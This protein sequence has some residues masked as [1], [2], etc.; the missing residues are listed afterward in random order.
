ME[1][2]DKITAVGKMQKYIDAN[3]E[4]EI[5]LEA[6]SRAAGYSKYHAA[7]IFKELTGKT[8]FE[9]VRALRLTRAA[10]ALRDTEGK[11]IDAALDHGF[12]SHDGF[13]RAFT[14]QFGVRPGDYSR[15]KP[16]V[17][18]FVHY[19]IEANYPPK[20]GET[21]M[22]QIRP[23]MTVTAME[24]PAR[25]LILV[26]SVKATDYFSFCEEI[27][28]E[29]EGLFNSI[30]EKFDNAALLTLPQNL[31]TPGTG[32]TASGVEVPIGYNKPLP[33]GCDIIELPPCTML[34]FQGAPYQEENSF[35]EAIMLLWEIMDEYDPALYGLKYAPELAPYF[36]FGA[37]AKTGARMARPVGKI[38]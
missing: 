23:T 25:K 7:R 37:E 30:K 1:L 5:T 12:E 2:S 33:G 14:R 32:N 29:W 4:G 38:I 34:Y 24:R 20:E 13:T 10:Q 8:P 19:P 9:T 22:E 16:P 11:V 21:A 3:L 31:V 17:R 27:G 36:N 35:G 18:W 15:E 26:R 28:C 6:L